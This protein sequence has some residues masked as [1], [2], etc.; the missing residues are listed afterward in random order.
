MSGF[1]IFNRSLAQGAL[2]REFRLSYGFFTPTDFYGDYFGALAVCALKPSSTKGRGE[3]VLA[4]SI[5]AVGVL[6]LLSCF[7]FSVF[8][9]GG[10]GPS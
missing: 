5:D 3:W 10:F 1:F 6:F 7:S 8:F 9:V 4:P 2:G